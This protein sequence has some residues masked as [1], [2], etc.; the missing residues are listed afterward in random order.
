MGAPACWQEGS[1][2]RMM[3][4]LEASLH[5]KD[6]AFVLGAI[7]MYMLKEAVELPGVGVKNY[8]F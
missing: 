5:F 4:Y 1:N 7:L 2:M 3:S 6:M 8:Q